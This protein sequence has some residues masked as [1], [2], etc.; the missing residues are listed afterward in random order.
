MGDTPYQEQI[1]RTSGLLHYWTFDGSSLVSR[2]GGVDLA[3]ANPPSYASGKV[4]EKSALFNGTNQSAY[5]ASA[6]NLAAY[7][8]LALS[9]WWYPNVYDTANNE[10]ILE[11]SANSNTNAGTFSLGARGDVAND[12][13]R[14]ATSAGNSTNY[15]IADYY[16]AT[17]GWATPAWHH[18]V[19]V[20]DKSKTSNQ[21]SLYRNGLLL[22]PNARPINDNVAGNFGNHTLYA[23]SRANSSLFANHTIDEL[24]LFNASGWTDADVAA[25]IYAAYPRSHGIWGRGPGKGLIA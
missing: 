18:L 2:H 21:V 5:T 24:C 3:A 8:K 23:G 16:A 9:L 7:N 11:F 15:N 10:L 6:L 12:P 22:S 13:L 19:V 17:F 14:I 20:Y 25:A 4:G 1:L